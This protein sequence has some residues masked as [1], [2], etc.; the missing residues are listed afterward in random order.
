MQIGIIGGGAAGMMC[1][2]K[3]LEQDSSQSNEIYIF[4]KNPRLGIKV[5]I[6]GGGRCNVTTGI[7]DLRILSAKYIR[8]ANFLKPALAAFP[9]HAVVEWLETHGVALKEERDQR[10]FPVSNRGQDIVAVFE[11]LFTDKHIHLHL[12]QA[13]HSVSKL[14]EKYQLTTQDGS[15]FQFD[16][17][18]ITTGGNAYQRT[19][20]TGDGY[21]F[22]KN[23]GHSI[24]KL[25]ASLNSFASQETWCHELAG[26]S[27]PKARLEFELAPEGNKSVTGPLIFTHFGISGPAVFSMAAHLAFADLS[28]ETPLKIYLIPMADLNFKDC[29]SII[30]KEIVRDG[31]KPL[32]VILMNFVPRHLAQI[33]LK[34]ANITA[35]KGAE[36]SK[37]ERQKLVHYLTSKLEINL[38]KKTAG[39]EFVTAG[40]ISLEEV[41]R[42]TMQSRL[43]KGL[44]FAGEILNIDGL[45]GG[46]NL[47]AAWA[48]GRMAGM[49]ITQL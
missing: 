6:T 3:I 23:L 38:I 44:Y 24:T 12:N 43:H 45:T 7:N 29:D 36:L 37:E 18:V 1:A 33:I 19:G 13:V 28:P 40:G 16:I 20:S 46:F 41:D 39:A 14:N 27:L 49:A 10:I 30:T 11:N 42:N 32:D 35:S 4:D 34:L 25:G 48:T 31:L 47:Q 2:A 8:G 21:T 22:A 5:S 17:L 26:V 15:T 9:P